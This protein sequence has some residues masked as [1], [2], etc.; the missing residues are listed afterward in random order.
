MF[1]NQQSVIAGNRGRGLD[2]ESF[3]LDVVMGLST[4]DMNN[5]LFNAFSEDVPQSG[6]ARVDINPITD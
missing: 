6:G 4:N 2:K 1:F 5:D 3:D